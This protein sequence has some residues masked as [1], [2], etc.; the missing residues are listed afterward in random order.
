MSLTLRKKPSR[1]KSSDKLNDQE[2]DKSIVPDQLDVT[3]CTSHDAIAAFDFGDLSRTP[4]HPAPAIRRASSPSELHRYKARAATGMP[5][6]VSPARSQVAHRT[7]FTENFDK[8]ASEPVTAA[9]SGQSTPAQEVSDPVM[10]LG[11]EH[12]LLTS[13]AD[14]PAKRRRSVDVLARARSR[15]S[16]NP[17]IRRV[18]RSRSRREERQDSA[19]D[20]VLAGTHDR[21]ASNASSSEDELVRPP[22][23]LDFNQAKQLP[24]TP[25]PQ[26]TNC[27]VKL[28]GA[29]GTSAPTNS[30]SFS[31]PFRFGNNHRKNNVIP[32][33]TAKSTN[34]TSSNTNGAPPDSDTIE[35]DSSLYPDPLTI[36]LPDA[37]VTTPIDLNGYTIP[38]PTSSKTENEQFPPATVPVCPPLYD[39]TRLASQQWVDFR[40]TSSRPDNPWGW[41]KRWTCCRCSAQTIVEQQ[42]CARMSCGHGRCGGRCIGIVR[43]E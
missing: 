22:P 5:P 18:T 37:K 27:G 17:T 16:G 21:K 15:S 13:S 9:G 1:R 30:P 7:A 28:S 14:S 2:S 10:V 19:S 35:R 32:L 33:S 12:D 6:I 42:S 3:E 11:D 41:H 26:Q 25:S 4:R 29:K 31:L 39:P 36:S 34:T 24:R 40:A 23:G 38:K 20:A 8:T 43:Q